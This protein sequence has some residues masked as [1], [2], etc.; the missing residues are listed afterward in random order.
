VKGYSRVAGPWIAT[1]TRSCLSFVY[2]RSVST[3]RGGQSKADPAE[4]CHCD[5][6]ERRSLPHCQKHEPDQ[7]E[8]EISGSIDRT[9]PD[10][11]VKRRAA[12]M[13]PVK[14]R[15]TFVGVSTF[16]ASPAAM[17]ARRFN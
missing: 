3:S 11:V 1:S 2:V 12:F 14:Y 5:D 6:D 9:C 17:N 10:W 7:R 8:P 15:E 13:R 4:R 16:W